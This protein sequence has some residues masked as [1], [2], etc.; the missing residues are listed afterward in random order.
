ML[1]DVEAER[2]DLADRLE[3]LDPAEWASPT[4]CA[5]W[6]VHEILAHLTL[7][8]RTPLGAMIRARG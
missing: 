6:T 5:A 3:T 8:T 1:P 2:L 7:S 4:L